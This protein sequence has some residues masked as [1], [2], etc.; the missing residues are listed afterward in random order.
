MMFFLFSLQYRLFAFYYMKYSTR[1]I[2]TLYLVE[3]KFLKI[4]SSFKYTTSNKL[5]YRIFLIF[6]FSGL[7]Y[8]VKTSCLLAYFKSQRY[9]HALIL[10]SFKNL[11]R[12]FL[13]Q[14]Q[15]K[16]NIL[17]QN[18]F[19]SSYTA[20]DVLFSSLLAVVSNMLLVVLVLLKCK[21]LLSF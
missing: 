17:F 16:L 6:P 19:V 21:L 5:E 10:T 7:F 14:L 3:G 1:K 4:M 11:R 2:I 18:L 12:I 13:E 8:T 20:L 15:R 9:W